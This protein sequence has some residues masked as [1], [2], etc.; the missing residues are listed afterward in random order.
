MKKT[1]IKVFL[2]NWYQCANNLDFKIPI[3][4]PHMH[5][6]YNIKSLSLNLFART[7]KYS[8]EQ[9]N[10]HFIMNKSSEVNS[11]EHVTFLRVLE[12]ATMPDKTYTL[13]NFSGRFF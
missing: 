5:H 12:I 2:Y 9:T 7:F 4:G 6:F 13:Q 1:C 10:S 3:C 11:Y 8:I